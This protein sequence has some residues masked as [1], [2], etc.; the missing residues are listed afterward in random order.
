MVDPGRGRGR[1][2][3]RYRARGVGGGRQEWE[4]EAPGQPGQEAAAEDAGRRG[5][6][7]DRMNSLKNVE[8]SSQVREESS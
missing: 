1:R 6:E 3:R 8:L 2:P 5:R 4:E 7:T